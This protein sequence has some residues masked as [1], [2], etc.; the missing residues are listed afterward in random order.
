MSLRE[1]SVKTG[2]LYYTI[3]YWKTLK[4]ILYCRNVA[5]KLREENLLRQ[6]KL[7]RFASFVTTHAFRY[8]MKIPHGIRIHRG[9]KYYCLPLVG[10]N[11][12]V[13]VAGRYTWWSRYGITRTTFNSVTGHHCISKSGYWNG[14]IPSVFGYWYRWI[15][16][17]NPCLVA[18]SERDLVWYRITVPLLWV[19]KYLVITL[20]SLLMTQELR[21]IWD[22]THF[23]RGV[24]YTS[25]VRHANSLL[26]LLAW[27]AFMK[28][29]CC[30]FSLVFVDVAVHHD[31][32][33]YSYSKQ[34]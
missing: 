17:S 10:N 31:L 23:W 16:T 18:Y 14:R 7:P 5:A 4:I 25:L 34:Q 3:Q 22:L 6:A 27:R 32:D 12:V 2:I 13:P 29:D 26:Y 24:P 19:L 8:Y 21:V 11:R 30:L 20:I 9:S 28:G 1:V 33:S 15:F